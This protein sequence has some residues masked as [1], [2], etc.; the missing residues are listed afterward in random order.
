MSAPRQTLEQCRADAVAAQESHQIKKFVA[1]CRRQWPGAE[2]VLR[3]DS[4]PTGA[5][6][7]PNLDLAPGETENF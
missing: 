6:A 1:A 7:P 5:N 2:I 4:A 3:S